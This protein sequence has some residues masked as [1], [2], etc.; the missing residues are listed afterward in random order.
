MLMNSWRSRTSQKE[1]NRNGLLKLSKLYPIFPARALLFV[2]ESKTRSQ[3]SSSSSFSE[4]KMMKCFRSG[5]KSLMTSIWAWMLILKYYNPGSKSAA[6][7]SKWHSWIWTLQYMA[8]ESTDVSNIE[9]VVMCIHWVNKKRVRKEYR[10]D[11]SRSKKYRYNCHLHQRCAAVYESQN[12]RCLWAVLW[13]MF[14]HYWNQKGAAAQ[15][16]KLIC[17]CTALATH[18]ILL[19]GI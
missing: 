1:E 18:L 8:D 2:R 13:W 10:S 12:S 15:I 11:A 5:F 9:Q 4:L 3:I 6:W 7:Y 16:K 17:W 19:S 14:D